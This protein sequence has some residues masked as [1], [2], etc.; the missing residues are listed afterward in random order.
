MKMPTVHH[1]P[2]RGARRLR[3]PTKRALASAH[4]TTLRADLRDALTL[5]A[6]TVRLVGGEVRLTEEDFETLDPH[7]RIE[8]T[9]DPETKDLILRTHEPNAPP[10]DDGD[11]L[12]EDAHRAKGD[13]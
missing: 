9:I 10:V 12:E 4:I 7:T 13:A 5:L 8:T 11:A 1:N 2:T 3:S 6:A